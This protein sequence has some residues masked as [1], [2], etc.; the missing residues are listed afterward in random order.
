MEG[1]FPVEDD[2]TEIDGFDNLHH[3]EDILK[4]A[5]GGCRTALW[6]AGEFLQY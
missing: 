2:I 1:D 5:A 6:C 4:R 3:A